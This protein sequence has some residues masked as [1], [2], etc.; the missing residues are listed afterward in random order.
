MTSADERTIDRLRRRLS[1][2]QFRATNLQRQVGQTRPGY[3]A[4]AAVRTALNALAPA[5]LKLVELGEALIDAG[6]T[7]AAIGLGAALD[8]A[9]EFRYSSAAI[10]ARAHIEI[11]ED[12]PKCLVGRLTEAAD[13]INRLSPALAKSLVELG[14]YKDLSEGDLQESAGESPLRWHRQSRKRRLNLT[15]ARS[16]PAL[17]VDNVPGGWLR[18]PA[19]RA[20]NDANQADFAALLLRLLRDEAGF[21]STSTQAPVEPPGTFTLSALAEFDDL[22]SDRSPLFLVCVGHVDPIALDQVVPGSVV[23]PVPCFDSHASQLIEARG[24]ATVDIPSPAYLLGICMATEIPAQSRRNIAVDC[25]PNENEEFLSFSPG[26][27]HLAVNDRLSHLHRQLTTAAT[28]SCRA[29]T[30]IA[31]QFVDGT[32]ATGTTERQRQA[33]EILDAVKAAFTFVAAGDID[34]AKLAWAN[35]FTARVHKSTTVLPRP[36]YSLPTGIPLSQAPDGAPDLVTAADHRI[37]EDIGYFVN[38][39][40]HHCAG[41][42][43]LHFLG[44]G[45]DRGTLERVQR[46]NDRV[47]LTYYEMT[48]IEFGDPNLFGRLTM[49][50][51]DRLM[52]PALLTSDR[53][54][55]LD[56]DVLVRCD[57]NEI[58]SV[59]LGNALVAA[60]QVATA[61]GRTGETLLRTRSSHLAD[62]T[63]IELA[64][65]VRELHADLTYRCFN[66][67]VQV[68]N[69]TKLRELDTVNLALTLA[70]NYSLNDQDIMNFIVG[71]AW[72]DLGPQFNFVPWTEISSNPQLVHYVGPFKPWGRHP[73]RFGSEWSADPKTR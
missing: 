71:P 25:R 31:T 49:S 18:L 70:R 73:V 56:L 10:N 21:S 50:T 57:I 60:A 63:A 41:D 48:E 65:T 15:D 43:S 35:S 46:D 1:L 4:Y 7:A 44:R 20:T 42:I 32:N 69:L 54:T 59:D 12:L 24:I 66:G 8:H 55:Y 27:S 68:L 34:G 9:P 38:A 53:A 62:E 37:Q 28:A 61:V 6:D 58:H 5:D 72:L 14:I 36:N 39:L 33:M 67:G 2:A 26:A 19:L 30:G 52:I 13:E 47:H 3:D 64:A 16:D 51:M 45:V 11:G 17:L 29:L 40:Q 22:L 23:E